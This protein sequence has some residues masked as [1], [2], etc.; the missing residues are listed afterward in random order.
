MAYYNNDIKKVI[1]ERKN[2]YIENYEN[3]DLNNKINLVKSQQDFY[4][5]DSNSNNLFNFTTIS[6]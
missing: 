6:I 1:K 2:G 3:D 4:N 5:K